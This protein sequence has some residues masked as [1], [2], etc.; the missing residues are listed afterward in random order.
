MHIHKG[1][2]I[3]N[4]ADLSGHKNEGLYEEAIRSLIRP[5]SLTDE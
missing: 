1:F 2:F 5:L 4:L 3:V